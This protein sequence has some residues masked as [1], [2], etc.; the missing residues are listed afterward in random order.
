[1]GSMVIGPALAALGRS[2]AI[3]SIPTKTHRR[4]IAISPEKSGAD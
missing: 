4:L 3:R 1:M 2:E